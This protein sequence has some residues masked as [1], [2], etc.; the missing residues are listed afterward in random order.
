MQKE[1]TKREKDDCFRQMKI[2]ESCAGVRI[3]FDARLRKAKS[4]HSNETR[5]ETHWCFAACDFLCGKT[6]LRGCLATQNP[7]VDM[8]QK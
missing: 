2:R 3:S 7:F 8:R 6:S 4:V 1:E 5:M